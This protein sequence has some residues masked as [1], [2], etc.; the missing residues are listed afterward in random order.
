MSAPSRHG[1]LADRSGPL[2]QVHSSARDLTKDK[3][4]LAGQRH[5][6]ATAAKRGTRLL[7][8]H[9]CQAVEHANVRVHRLATVATQLVHR[10]ATVATG[11]VHRL[12]TVA[13]KPAKW[14]CPISCHVSL[15]R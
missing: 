5:S 15:T 12:A 6:V 10:L 2:I 3:R 8:S 13:T 14:R 4:C 9:R 7:G 11:L 1:R